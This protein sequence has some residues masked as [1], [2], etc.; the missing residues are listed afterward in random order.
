M[1][2]GTI[3]MSFYLPLSLLYCMEARSY[4]LQ[5]LSGYQTQH[6]RWQRCG[7]FLFLKFLLS[8]CRK[9]SMMHF[10]RAGFLPT[11][12]EGPALASVWTKLPQK[13][14]QMAQQAPNL[15]LAASLGM[16]TLRKAWHPHVLPGT[17]ARGSSRRM[18]SS[19]WKRQPP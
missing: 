1:D 17:D 6:P 7:F 10:H 2:L 15:T 14:F 4:Q 12:A 9:R 11:G 16:S 13:G 5:R 18:L 19:Y 8:A 3:T